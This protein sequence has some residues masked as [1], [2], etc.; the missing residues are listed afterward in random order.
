MNFDHSLKMKKTFLIV[1]NLIFPVRISKWINIVLGVIFWIGGISDI[2][3]GGPTDMMLGILFFIAGA[4]LIFYGFMVLSQHSKYAP[5]LKIGNDYIE[6]KTGILKHVTRIYWKDIESIAFGNFEMRFRMA[7]K[8]RVFA[9]HADPE[10]SVAMKHAV[11]EMAG[12]KNID[13]SIA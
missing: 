6:Y 2:A 8:E 11:R 13:V 7:G 4:A 1:N 10:I 5:R 9:Y 12:E 3:R